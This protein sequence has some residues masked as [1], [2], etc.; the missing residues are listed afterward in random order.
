MKNA[1][2]QARR[3]P[4]TALKECNINGVVLRMYDFEGS[5]TADWVADELRRDEYQV[6]GIPF[7]KDDVVIDLGAHVGFISIYLA[8]KFPFIRFMRSSRCRSTIGTLQR[9]PESTGRR[10]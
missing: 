8:K 4:K 5:V 2:G 10:T 9:T 7:E 6:E 1:L 3:G